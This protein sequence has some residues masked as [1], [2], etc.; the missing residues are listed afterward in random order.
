MKAL[1]TGP[2]RVLTC[3][4]LE[5]IH[6]SSFVIAFHVHADGPIVLNFPKFDSR[7]EQEVREQ[8]STH[9]LASR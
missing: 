1:G 3:S 2:K 5:A 7:I 8:S 6:E 9:R 4:T